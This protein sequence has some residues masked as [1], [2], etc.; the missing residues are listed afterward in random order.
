ME[1]TRI[2]SEKDLD[3]K[4]ERLVIKIGDSEITLTEEHGNL[5]IHGDDSDLFI[6]CGSRNTFLVITKP[7]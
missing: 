5:R 6:S 4:V 2:D 1:I 3:Q 7:N